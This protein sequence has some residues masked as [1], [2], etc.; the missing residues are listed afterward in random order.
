MHPTPTP[1][2]DLDPYKK[3]FQILERK[4]GT[5]LSMSMLRVLVLFSWILNKKYWSGLVD[6]S[7]VIEFSCSSN[8]DFCENKISNMQGE[9][10]PKSDSMGVVS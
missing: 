1:S 9:K 7:F 5:L 10:F 2:S 4:L 8:F 3:R 6:S